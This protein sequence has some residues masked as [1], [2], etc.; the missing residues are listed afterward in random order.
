MVNELGGEREEVSMSH[1][2]AMFWH[3]SS[4]KT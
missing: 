4:T 2:N 1:I 3:C